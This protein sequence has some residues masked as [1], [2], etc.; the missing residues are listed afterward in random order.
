MPNVIE[1][2]IVTYPRRIYLVTQNRL[3]VRPNKE[4]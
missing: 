1:D 4:A 2:F 3:T